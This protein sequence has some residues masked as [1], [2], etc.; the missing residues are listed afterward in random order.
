MN[1][2]DRVQVIKYKEGYTDPTEDIIAV[3]DHM[4]T[5]NGVAHSFSI[6]FTTQDDFSD[7]ALNLMYEE[8][9]ETMFFLTYATWLIKC[10]NAPISDIEKAMKKRTEH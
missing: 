8:K 9:D 2:F 3:L 7:I 6:P 1:I 4:L 5:D 10:R